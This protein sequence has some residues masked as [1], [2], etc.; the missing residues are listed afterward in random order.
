MIRINK[1][2][3]VPV[4]K[5]TD[6]TPTPSEPLGRHWFC[7]NCGTLSE[8]VGD[9]FTSIGINVHRE[10]PKCKAVWTDVYM[11]LES[12]DFGWAEDER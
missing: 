5:R 9:D 6:N 1:P 4:V 10:C 7:V 3:N 12:R 8:V 2:V 11:H